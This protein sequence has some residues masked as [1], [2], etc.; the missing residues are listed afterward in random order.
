MEKQGIKVTTKIVISTLIPIFLLIIIFLFVVNIKYIS[1]S[2]MEPILQKGDIIFVNRLSK[3][4]KRGDI[5]LCNNAGQSCY[6]RVIGVP[7]DTVIT[8]NGNI[9]V[10]GSMIEENYLEKGIKIIEDNTFRVPDNTYF[11]MGDNK[12][13]YL[14]QKGRKKV[15]VKKEDVEGMIFFKVNCDKSEKLETP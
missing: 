8:N 5:I 4:Y 12:E 10:N 9:T 3:T 13:D 2:A 6:K 15:Y 7:G 11:V 1:S 14:G